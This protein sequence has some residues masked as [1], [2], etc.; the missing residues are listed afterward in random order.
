MIIV[1]EIVKPYRSNVAHGRIVL[2]LKLVLDAEG[3]ADLM[4]LAERE[5]WQ[6]WDLIEEQ[7]R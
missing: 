2:T 5:Q 4:H 3:L 6:N 7:S 1:A